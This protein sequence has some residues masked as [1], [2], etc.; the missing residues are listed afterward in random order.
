VL[1]DIELAFQLP[2]DPILPRVSVHRIGGSL[3][4]R[5]S[6]VGAWVEHDQVECIDRT[7]IQ[8]KSEHNAD[9][10]TMASLQPEITS[11]QPTLLRLRLLDL[12]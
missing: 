5:I 2:D 4:P 12:C 8:L 3:F 10:V 1:P 9:C 7:A 11:C 6:T